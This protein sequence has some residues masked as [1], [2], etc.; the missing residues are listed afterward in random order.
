MKTFQFIESARLLDLSPSTCI[1][2][3]DARSI[4]S[5]ARCVVS[6]NCSVSRRDSASVIRNSFW[7][8]GI[9]SA[10][11]ITRTINPKNA[12]ISHTQFPSGWSGFEFTLNCL[13]QRITEIIKETSSGTSNTTPIQTSHSPHWPINLAL[14]SAAIDS[15]LIDSTG[16]MIVF[17]G[18]LATAG[19]LALLILAALFVIWKNRR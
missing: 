15:G 6:S 2:F 11:P 1:S 12:T 14:S 13:L 10:S 9:S 8:A 7:C 3:V 5:P 4:A 18:T 17:Y 16:H 19:S